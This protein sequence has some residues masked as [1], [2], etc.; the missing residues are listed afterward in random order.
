MFSGKVVLITGASSGIGA[1]VAVR[2]AEEGAKLALT[3]RNEKNLEDTANKCREKNNLEPLVIPGDLTVDSDVKNIVDTTIKTYER[4]DVL[5]NNAGYLAIAPL[6]SP[7]IMDYFDKTF[8][9]NVRSVYLLTNLAIP[10]LI[11]SKGNIVNV[12]SAAS[13]RAFPLRTGYAMSK[14]AL[15]HF[16]RC[17][18]LE[19][20]PKQVRVNAVNPG[21]VRTNIH[22][23]SGMSDSQ[24]A[25]HRELAKSIH[26]VGRIGEVSDVS[27]AILFL[28][29]EDASFITGEC[30]V[31]DGGLTVSSPMPIST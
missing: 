28:A 9:T 27:R 8:D 23:N 10:Y 11:E 31:V 12:S 16:T 30:L 24:L 29:G 17:A 25:S 20:A 22:T 21:T 13:I 26:P 5:V 6:A 3:G 2:F 18:A 4:L 15:D 19:L 14:A 7:D 1:D